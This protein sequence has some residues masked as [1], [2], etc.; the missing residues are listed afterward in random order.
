MTDTTA[1][2]PAVVSETRA[3][4]RP[5]PRRAWGLRRRILLIFTLGSLLLS[6]LSLLLLLY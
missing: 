3:I 2:I 1:E 6:L 5:N 4:P